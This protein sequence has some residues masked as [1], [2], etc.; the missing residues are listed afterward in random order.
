MYT[1]HS[2]TPTAEAT[3]ME[4]EQTPATPALLITI[5][6]AAVMFGSALHLA[7]KKDIR[8]YLNGICLRRDTSTTAILDA[9]D[10][11]VMGRYYVDVVGGDTLPD[12]GLIIPRDAIEAIVKAKAL[13]VTI[14]ADYLNDKLVIIEM[15]TG[16]GSTTLRV[17]PE[18]A[19]YPDFQPIMDGVQTREPALFQASI[20]GQITKAGEV[21]AKARKACIGIDVT[22]SGQ[23]VATAHIMSYAKGGN[24]ERIASVYV[25]PMRR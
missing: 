14:S 6:D 23:S 3:A 7:A 13:D 21:I 15:S 16:K 11:H 17:A 20:L 12:A 2:Y 18:V 9:T 5:R 8:F 4:A 19:R 24:S 1:D 22:T 10:G 25:M